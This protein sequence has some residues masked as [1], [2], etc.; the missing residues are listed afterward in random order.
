MSSLNQPTSAPVNEAGADGQSNKRSPVRVIA[1]VDTG[2]DDALA[3]T[4]LVRDPGVDLAAVTCVAGNANVDQVVQNTLDVLELAGAGSTP[5]GRGAERPLINEARTAHGFHGANGIADL[6]LPRSPHSA[7]ELPALE[8]LRRTIE[9]SEV[10]VTLLALAPLT[11]IALFVRA[12]PHTA[13]KL[14]RI[15]FM[16]GSVGMGNATAVAEFNAW[17]D[18]EAL[19]V[20]LEAG[21]PVTMYGLDVFYTATLPSEDYLPLLSSADAGVRL[22]GELL[23]H[24]GSKESSDPRLKGGATLGDAGAACLVARPETAVLQKF[25][26]SVELAGGCRGKTIVDQ[27][28]HEGESELHGTT[29]RNSLI[30]VAMSIDRDAMQRLFMSTVQAG[31]PA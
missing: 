17:H 26:V 6:E 2:V 29:V 21:V 5:V 30:N 12:Y 18:P 9:E 13:R 28:S 8:L 15:V 20:V 1:D 19:S 25:P 16:G 4:F 10:P 7:S 11:N 27:R 24:S 14:E 3:L 23:R 22:V 31:C